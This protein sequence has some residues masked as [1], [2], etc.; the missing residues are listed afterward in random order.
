MIKNAKNTDII[1]SPVRFLRIGGGIL[2]V[3]LPSSGESKSTWAIKDFEIF[4]VK[5]F[6]KFLQYLTTMDKKYKYSV[7]SGEVDGFIPWT[8][9]VVNKKVV[10]I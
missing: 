1:Y 6:I 5:K 3:D 10:F 9:K 2:L 4:D 7:S 8:F